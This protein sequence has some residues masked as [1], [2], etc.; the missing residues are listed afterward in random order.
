V[1]GAFRRI[2][3]TVKTSAALAVIV[4]GTNPIV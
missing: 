3:N 4:N 2:P 1:A